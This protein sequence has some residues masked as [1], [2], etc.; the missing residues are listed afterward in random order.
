MACAVDI[1]IHQLQIGIRDRPPGQLV[2]DVSMEEQ[3]YD[4][5]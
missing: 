1:T 4:V 2:N 3:Y 5:S